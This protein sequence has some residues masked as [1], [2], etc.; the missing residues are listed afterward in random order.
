[1]NACGY[2]FGTERLE[3]TQTVAVP[4]FANQTLRR[5][6]ERDLTRDVL[7]EIKESTTYLIENEKSADLIIRGEILAIDETV[8][9]EGSDDQVL[10]SNIEVTVQVELLDSEGNRLPVRRQT[11]RGGDNY[12]SILKDRAEFIPSRGETRDTATR[13]ALREMAERIVQILNTY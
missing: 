7:R 5:G 9:V 1:M 4:V 11:G 8:L 12:R 10:E 2:R 13:E 3:D 6:F